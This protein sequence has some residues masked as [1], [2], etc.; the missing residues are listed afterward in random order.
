MKTL[1]LLLLL[2]SLALAQAPADAPLADI[3]GTSVRLSTGQEAP[4]PGRLV[5]DPESVRREKVN[6]RLAGELASL[7]APENVTLTKGALVGIAAGSAV[8]AAIVAT[9]IVLF[10]APTK[11]P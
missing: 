6:E 11:K 5:S 10:V 7:K 4:F 2:P 9:V 3:P 8:A 1:F